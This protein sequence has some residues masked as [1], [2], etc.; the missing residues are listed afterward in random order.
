M[1]SINECVNNS[2]FFYF[3]YQQSLSSTVLTVNARKF[4]S[5]THL[6]LE[7]KEITPFW[8]T[9][10]EIEPVRELL[11][12][13]FLLDRMREMSK[14]YCISSYCL[15]WLC[16][17]FSSVFSEYGSHLKKKSLKKKSITPLLTALTWLPISWIAVN[18]LIVAY[19]S[20]HSTHSLVLALF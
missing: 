12:N 5:Q 7:S 20:L 9:E 16:P 14:D 13:I 17:C 2:Y 18:I 4:L 6:Q 19:K 15:Y 1:K 11:A 3:S 8:P 10:P